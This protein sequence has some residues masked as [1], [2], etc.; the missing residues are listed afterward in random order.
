MDQTIRNPLAMQLHSQKNHVKFLER[1]KNW[2]N[3]NV[4]R[5]KSNVVDFKFS[6]KKSNFSKKMYH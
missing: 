4:A 2:I 5:K 6:I 1:H 3:K